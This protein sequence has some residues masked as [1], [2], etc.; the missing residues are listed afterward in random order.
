M[1]DKITQPRDLKGLSIAELEQLAG[2][3]REFLIESISRTGGHIGANLGVVELTL[4]V[5]YVFDAPNDSILF[6]VGHQGYTHKLLTGRKELFPTLNTFGGMSRFISRNES[7]FD[8]LDASHAGTSLSIATGM[9]Y[10]RQMDRSESI[11]VAVVGDGALVEGMSFEGLNFAA[12][13]GIPLIIIINDNG[14]SIPRNIGGINNLFEHGGW[15]ERSGSFFRGF[16]YEY[17]AVPDGHDIPSLVETLR[18]AQERVRT[19]GVVVHV[20]TEKGKGLAIARDHPYKMHFSMP[21]DPHTGS[22]SSPVPPGM[23]YSRIVGETL[24]RFLAE[25][26]D[27][28]VLTPATPYASGIEKCLEDFPERA[29]DV[30][31]A[32]QHCV[33]M[34]TGLALKGKKVFACFQSTFLQRSLDQIFH[35]A[36]YMDLTITIIAARSGFSGFDS[37]THHGIYDLSYLRAIPNLQI[38]YAGTSP[39]LRR[40]LWQRHSRPTG[41]PLVILHP[42]ENIW[43][44]GDGSF[45]ADDDLSK[46]SVAFDGKDGFIFSTG[47]RLPAAFKLRELIAQ[48]NLDFGVLNIRWIS[49][50]PVGQL[51]RIMKRAPR[52]VTLEENV[53]SAG[54]GSAVNE[55]I[56]AQRLSADLFCSAIDDGFVPAGDKDFLSRLTGIDAESVFNQ[57]AQRWDL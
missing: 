35:D 49:P 10:A 6:D 15:E 14:M 17:L 43:E 31:M 57:L 50:L 24:Y 4:A 39:D 44:E 9:A 5:H 26:E 13:R 54:F 32:E 53:R 2:E 38:F 56:C 18:S 42:Y 55:I 48:R 41:G 29:Y 21:F 27:T 37:P 8:E 20:K 47:N 52:I 51:T 45:P 30:G 34:A 16:G 40:I 22:G 23:S 3:V 36:C 1:L 7:R 19:G 25:D 46:A 12:E 11:V 33:G 28:V